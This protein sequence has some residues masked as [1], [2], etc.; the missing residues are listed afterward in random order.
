VID[1]TVRRSANTPRN[2]VLED[3]VGAEL[4]DQVG[5]TG[6]PEYVF[7][8][9]LIRTLSHMANVSEPEFQ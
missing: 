7:H 8:H 4:I 1:S 2:P 3:L 9:P 6:Q 5:F